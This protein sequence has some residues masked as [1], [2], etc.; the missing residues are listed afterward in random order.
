M[1]TFKLITT[2]ALAGAMT[3]MTT[4]VF[5][6]DRTTGRGAPGLPVI[7]V[8]SQDAFYDT[9]L[10]ADLPFNGND[11]F[12]LL[13]FGGPADAYTEFGPTDTG[14]Y[15]GRWWVDL[16]EDGYMD[17]E[18]MFFLCPLLGPGRDEP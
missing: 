6:K 3:L 8:T 17:E 13:E 16:N 14:Y 18:D 9:L 4:T 1:S 10:L 7:Y 2:I 12:Q 15:G 5:A 11:N